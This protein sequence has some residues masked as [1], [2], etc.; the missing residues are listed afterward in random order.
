MLLSAEN[1]H[2]YVLSR[3]AII[4]LKIISQYISQHLKKGG[5][6]DVRV[7]AFDTLNYGMLLI[8]LTK[9]LLD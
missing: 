2:G 7:G 6:V 5:Q 9:V 8:K 1:Q 4:N 3:S